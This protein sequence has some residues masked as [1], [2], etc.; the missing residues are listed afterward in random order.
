VLT[1]F[2]QEDLQPEAII[3][4]RL[5]KKGNSAIPQ[6]R[7]KWHN[8]FEDSTTWVDWYVLIKAFP[9]ATS[10]GQDG[11]SAGGGVTVPM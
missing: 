1:D 8:L 2:S 6:V 7:V 11:S 5:V 10:W 4:R 9:S 3:E